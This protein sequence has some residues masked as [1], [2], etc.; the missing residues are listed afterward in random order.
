VSDKDYN[1]NRRHILAG[2]TALGGFGAFARNAVAQAPATAPA[3][4]TWLVL[5][6]TQ[7]GPNVNTERNE[8][9]SAIVIDGKVY[10]IDCGY[11]SMGALNESGLGLRN[12]NHIF[13]THLHDDHTSDL[14]ALLS[15]QWTTN[16]S[17]PTQV[18]GPWGTE[19]LVDAALDFAEANAAIRLADEDRSTGLDDLF[20][21]RDIDAAT[22]PTEIFSDDR[23]TVTSVE[24]THFPDS[25]R[26]KVDYRAVSYRFDSRDRS[27]TISGD[28]A[29][30]ENLVR[31]AEGS[32]VFVCETIDVPS[33]RADF[34]RRV[35]EGAYADNPEGVWNHIV[36]THTSTEDAGRMAAEAGVET[37]VL[38]H[39]VPG[40][41]TENS[42]NLFLEGASRHF[43]GRIIVGRDLMVI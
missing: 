5:L 35:A 12:A 25:A 43:N 41:I 21:G 26:R 40:G 38:T 31:L 2:L 22:N 15:H 20:S 18:I 36:G 4:G 9:S 10:M 37:L 14:V 19:R 8:C 6:G 17:V 32:E 23:V 33:A 11:G 7:G 34:E 27:I 42:D 1:W 16:I 13:L 30:S 3:R 39:L 28:T 24:N 29:P